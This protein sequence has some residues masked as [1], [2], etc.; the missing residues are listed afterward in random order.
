ML[1]YLYI[2]IYI[3]ININAFLNMPLKSTIRLEN[4]F[5]TLPNVL[6]ILCIYLFLLCHLTPL[7]LL[8]N[9]V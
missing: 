5:Y 3:Y 9:Q 6:P 7:A 8:N 4:I 2:Y 1:I